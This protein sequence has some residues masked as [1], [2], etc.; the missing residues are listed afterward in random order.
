[1][2]L[3]R[4][5]SK[6]VIAVYVQKY[7]HLLFEAKFS[8]TMIYDLTGYPYT[9]SPSV[10]YENPHLFTQKERELISI[11]ALGQEYGLTFAFETY[12]S[13]KCVLKREGISSSLKLSIKPLIIDYFQE[14]FMRFY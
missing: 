4:L 8:D 1:M 3:Y 7:D 13:K 12:N 6:K 10:Y 9:I 11:K 14:S 5:D 2:D